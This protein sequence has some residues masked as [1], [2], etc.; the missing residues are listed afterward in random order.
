MGK[1]EDELNRAETEY[2]LEQIELDTER[3]ERLAKNK[4]QREEAEKWLKF[5]RQAEPIEYARWL[6]GYVERDGK[7]TQWE[8]GPFPLE[9]WLVAQRNF[10]VTELWDPYHVDLIV[11]AHIEVGIPPEWRIGENRVFWMKDYQISQSPYGNIELQ[12]IEY[13][14]DVVPCFS[15]IKKLILEMR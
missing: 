4:R 7:I 6:K 14:Y 11:P 9:R 3:S 5:C 1:V 12:I 15:D 8:D 2:Q 10:D 13:D